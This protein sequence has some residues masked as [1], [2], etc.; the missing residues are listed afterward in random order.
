LFGINT[1]RILERKSRWHRQNSADLKRVRKLFKDFEKLKDGGSSTK[2]RSAVAQHICMELT[3][4]AKVVEGI[5]LPAI[6]E[7]LDKDDRR[8][9]A[10]VGRNVPKAKKAKLDMAQLGE[11]IMRRKQE[12][13]ANPNLLSTRG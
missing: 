4:R 13:Q 9:E 2:G 1:L 7:A 5:F 10:D 8:K 11:R 3:V 12:L 6:R